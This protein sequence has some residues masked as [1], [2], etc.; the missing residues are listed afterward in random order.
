MRVEVAVVIKAPRDY[1]Y[2]KY[3]DPNNWPRLSPSIKSVRNVRKEEGEEVAEQDVEAM[4]R[5]WKETVRR[6]YF[7]MERI[8]ERFESDVVTGTG[9]FAFADVPDGTRLTSTANVTPRGTLARLLGSL[10]GGRMRK[11]A[12]EQLELG[13]KWAEGNR[14]RQE[15][16]PE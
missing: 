4:G 2:S 3:A 15:P 11:I 10:A 7:P 1:V 5:T 6:K 12:Q 14:S 16:I 9:T 13:A 8:E